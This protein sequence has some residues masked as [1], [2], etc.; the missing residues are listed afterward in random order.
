MS[1]TIDL[2]SDLGEF[3]DQEHL[4]LAARVLA[5]VTSVNIACG[6][7]AG[8]PT[9]MR[10]TVRMALGHDVAIG[11]H[12][13][14]QDPEHFGRRELPVSPEEILEL[15]ASQVGAL[16]GIASLE[17]ARLTHVKPHGGLYHVVARDPACANGFARG[18][19]AV[20]PR[21]MVVGLAGSSVM[22]E[23]R[24]LGF[25]A[26]E[27]A[28]AD[29]AYH[30]DGTLVPRSTPGAVISNEH[31]VCQRALDIVQNGIARGLE[32]QAIPVR[33]K[34]ICLHGDTPGADHLTRAV[35]KSLTSAGVAVTRMDHAK[36]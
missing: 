21:L 24:V 1:L 18:V 29:R 35:R 14:F 16:A 12:P 15:V 30:Q 27:E 22:T 8:N 9:L 7:H 20:D 25:T 4:D 31:E 6:C 5:Q 19:L 2:N 3:G 17:G 13:G 10:A 32:G 33:G 11:A 26:V 34:T 23:A 28:F 36:A